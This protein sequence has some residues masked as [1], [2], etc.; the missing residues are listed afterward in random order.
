MGL[1][2]HASKTR[3]LAVQAQPFPGTVP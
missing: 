2:W 1:D 3:T